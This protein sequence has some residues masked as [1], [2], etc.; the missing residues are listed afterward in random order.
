MPSE[1]SAIL[2]NFNGEQIEYILAP[3]WQLIRDWGWIFLP[4][5]LWK[6]FTFFWL[7]WRQDIWS[8]KVYRPILLEIK[9]PKD[10]LKPIRAM[11]SI[12]ASI[13]AATY[14]P[15][16]W[17]EIWI[18][19]EWQTALSFEIA[20][21]NGETHFF[22][23]V[24]QPLRD[25]VEASIFAQYPEAEI[26]LAE[27]YTKYVPQDVPNKEWDL[28]GWDYFMNKESFY[29]IKT[30]LKYE[31]EREVTE[32]KIIDPIA[33]ILE[34]MAKMK[35]GE[36][37]WMQMR[38]KPIG[39]ERLRDFIKEAQEFRNVLA[40]RKSKPKP[41][42]AL[43]QMTQQVADVLVWGET[44]IESEKKEEFL[45]PEM[46]LTPGEREVVMEIERKIS[47]P[48]FQVGIR[49][50]Y[51]GKRDIWFKTNFR[52][53]FAFFN[54]FADNNLNALYPIGYTISKVKKSW[55]LPLNWILPRRRYLKCRHL[56]RMY[57]SR[58]N[59]LYPRFEGD[60][61]LFFM[62]TEEL[63]SIFHFPSQ[64]AAPAPLLSRIGS[65][66]G[67]PPVDLPME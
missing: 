16:D 21:F 60:K 24:F 2:Q 66:K 11:E 18:D 41:K 54:S 26:S 56:F 49:C 27:D 19:G 45:P 17:W 36:N 57:R 34:G 62:N 29:P 32:E 28:F 22:I 42:S 7:F 38:A 48:I 51:V 40:Q 12:M 59:W 8:E 5:L 43:S 25:A 39:E 52:L 67:E 15:P 23:R 46:K 3:F 33:N 50:L 65:K 37:F 64:A 4:F 10:I 55:F 35:P 61:G 53:F 30:Y 14:K 47:K 58:V 9:I 1:I 13:Q 44:R 20:S 31:T 6:P 63:A